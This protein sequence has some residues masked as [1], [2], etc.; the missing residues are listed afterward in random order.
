MDSLC[1]VCEMRYPPASGV[2]FTPKLVLESG[3]RSVE[4]LIVSK[5]ALRSKE[6]SSLT[7]ISRAEDIIKSLKESSFCGVVSTI[8][9]L[10]VVMIVWRGS[11]MWVKLR[12][13]G[14]Y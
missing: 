5:A 3:E 12:Q 14:V 7:V 11:N 6:T 9:R 1:A 8:S 4:W 10:E 13:E 2:S